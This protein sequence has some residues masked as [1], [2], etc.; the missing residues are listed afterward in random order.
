MIK[1]LVL[2]ALLLIPSVGFAQES[3]KIAYVKYEEIV[4]LMQEYTQMQDSLKK[5]S[6]IY[7]DQIKTDQEE[8]ENKYADYLEKQSTLAENI[9]KRR[10][11][12]LLDMRNRIM[13]FQQQAQQSLQQ[14]QES[15]LQAIVEKVNKAVEE[16][17]TQNHYAYVI[18]ASVARYI[19]PQSPDATPLVKAKLGL[20]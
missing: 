17:G 9:K 8:Y 2:F 12:D 13:L 5:E 19:S 10:E 16:I 6:A 18:D 20:K 3:Q 11:Q 1:K 15:L 7:E 4:P 14:L